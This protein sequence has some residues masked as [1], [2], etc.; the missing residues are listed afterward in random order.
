M[1][2]NHVHNKYTTTSRE[3]FGHP[4]ASP[5]YEYYMPN[6][7]QSFGRERQTNEGSVKWFNE[8]RRADIPEKVLRD[9][10]ES[11]GVKIRPTWYSE[12]P[13]RVLGARCADRETLLNTPDYKLLNRLPDRERDLKEFVNLKEGHREHYKDVTNTK[14]KVDFFHQ[15]TD[16]EKMFGVKT[17]ESSATIGK[18]PNTHKAALEYTWETERGPKHYELYHGLSDLYYHKKVPEI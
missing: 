15:P 16:A 2:A 4:K 18:F 5:A 1:C 7:P 17:T 14:H 9:N 13:D 8:Y 10:V 6:R 11:V 3:A 12:S